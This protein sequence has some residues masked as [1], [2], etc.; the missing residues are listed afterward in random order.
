MG[1]TPTS[2]ISAP[3][4]PL[5]EVDT[6]PLS[7]TEQ[8]PHRHF[9][10]RTPEP[11]QL[12]TA[13]NIRELREMIRYRY[14]LD[15]E[16]WKQKDVKEY[17]RG[18]LEENMRKSVA[19]L[20]DIRK[21][22]QGWDR[23]E[24]FASDLEHR[25]FQEIGKRLLTGNKMDWEKNKPWEP[26]FNNMIPLRAPF[27]M[28]GRT[29]TI[30]QRSA[31]SSFGNRQVIRERPEDVPYAR[32]SQRP[33]QIS[34]QNP[35]QRSRITRDPVRQTQHVE[36]TPQ[37]MQHGMEALHQEQYDVQPLRQA[38]YVTNPTPQMQYAAD[39]VRQS[40]FVEGLSQ[41][42]MYALVSPQQ[43]ELSLLSSQRSELGVRSPPPSELAPGSPQSTRHFPYI[44]PDSHRTQSFVH[45]NQPTR[46]YGD[47]SHQQ[48]S[49]VMVAT[50]RQIE[51]SRLSRQRD[52]RAVSTP[53]PLIKLTAAT[54]PVGRRVL[55]NPTHVDNV[56]YRPVRTDSPIPRG[57][58]EGPPSSQHSSPGY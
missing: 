41:Q 51:D 29:E 26:A 22:V 35:P 25:K 19:V 54:P 32:Q 53:T 20:A 13:E 34:D 15:V 5:N 24:F 57:R 47:L 45:N 40:Q 33:N 27:E 9:L 30:A 58:V 11:V 55:S 48:Q 28:G 6:S 49:G 39:S 36:S 3:L 38:P 10:Q 56:K 4:P 37:Q 7:S 18:N 31:P 50:P 43:S 21:M 8:H 12:V 16:I 52:I 23:R 14:S 17:M 2:D 1:R 46:R 44:P 42:E